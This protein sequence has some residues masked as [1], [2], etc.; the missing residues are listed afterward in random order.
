MTLMMYSDVL[1]VTEDSTDQ[2]KEVKKWGIGKSLHELI[3]V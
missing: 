2:G 1:W 3:F